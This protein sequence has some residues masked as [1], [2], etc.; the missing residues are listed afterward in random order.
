MPTRWTAAANPPWASWNDSSP[1]GEIRKPHGFYSWIDFSQTVQSANFIWQKNPWCFRFH[2]L[3]PSNP[4][5]ASARNPCLAQANTAWVGVSDGGKAHTI[6]PSPSPSI[7]QG[8]FTRSLLRRSSPN[9]IHT[10]AKKWTIGVT[11]QWRMCKC[12]ATVL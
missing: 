4:Y 11:R 12:C 3:E 9:L 2:W 1:Q 10:F 7:R 8:F 5:S 6:H